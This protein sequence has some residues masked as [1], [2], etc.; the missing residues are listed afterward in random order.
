MGVIV[1]DDGFRADRW[2]GGFVDWRD[3]AALATL[4]P[5]TA[6]DIPNTLTGEELAGAL[7]RL[8]LIRIAF[9]SHADGRGFSIARRLRLLGYRGRLR[10]RGHLLPD[11]YGM[12][13]RC[14]FDEVEIDDARAARQPEEQWLFRADWREH[15]YRQRLRQAP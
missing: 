11:Q 9:P 10:A 14:G 4:E 6:L 3:G 13:R 2:T 12:A 5:G 1:D 15:D 8:A 7:D